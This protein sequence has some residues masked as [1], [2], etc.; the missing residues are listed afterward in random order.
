MAADSKYFVFFRYRE[1]IPKIDQYVERVV[2][3]YNMDDFRKFFRM[4]R[5]TFQ[6]ICEQLGTLNEFK[7][8]R[9]R[10]MLGA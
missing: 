1:K 8:E 5:Q 10:G 3:L 6:V 2:P 7:Q 9:P 4:S